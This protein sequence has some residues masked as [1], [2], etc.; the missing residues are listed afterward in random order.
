MKFFDPF[1]DIRVTG[2]RFPHWQQSGAT[3]FITF[4]LADSL[5]T[6][7]LKALK[8]ERDQ[9]C[10]E[11]PKPWNHLTEMEYHRLFSAKIDRWLDQGYGS[12]LLA[13]PSNARI[14]MDALQHFEGMRSVLLMPNHVHTLVTLHHDQ[15]VDRLIHSWKS[16][17][18]HKLGKPPIWQRDYF[19]RLIRDA[20][21]FV[22][23]RRYIRNN[24]GKAK[25]QEGA[26]LLHEAPATWM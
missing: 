1:G 12:C 10:D 17:T 21:H 19:D 24:P 5:P 15:A 13:D 2:D 4:R 8:Q 14:V 20:D 7:K 11:H 6:E 23:V 3:Y 25:P 16:F 18:A 22:N 26:F 9:W